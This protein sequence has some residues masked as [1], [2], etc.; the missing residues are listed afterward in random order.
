MVAAFEIETVEQQPRCRIAQVFDVYQKLAHAF[1][2]HV[3]APEQLPHAGDEQHG[4]IQGVVPQL[5]VIVRIYGDVLKTAL[6]RAGQGSHGIFG[7]L[8]AD[9]QIVFPSGQ[10]VQVAQRQ[11]RTHAVYVL[12]WL[13][14]YA[15]VEP[16]GQVFEHFAVTAVP[17]VLIQP[18]QGNAL[19]PVPGVHEMG[20][21]PGSEGEGI[22]FIGNAGDYPADGGIQNSP[23]HCR[24][25]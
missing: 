12:D 9:V 17:I 14:V 18:E 11:K 2:G 6:F 7:P 23:V 1:F 20:T 15:L 16:A 3:P 19:E 24:A 5:H 10:F 25:S 4:H 8:R 22:S 21:V 13:A